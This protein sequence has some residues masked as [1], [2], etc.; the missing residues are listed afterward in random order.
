MDSNTQI[1][2][3]G[4]NNRMQR[5]TM[6]STIALELRHEKTTPNPFLAR[7]AQSAPSCFDAKNARFGRRRCID[8]NLC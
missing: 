3:I 6:A 8:S 4:L 5:T 2:H 1:L 7:A